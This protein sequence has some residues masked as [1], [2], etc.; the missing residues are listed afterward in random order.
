M[1]R[2]SQR[3]MQEMSA[4][5][6]WMAKRQEFKEKAATKNSEGETVQFKVALEEKEKKDYE[7]A[8]KIRL[9]N[10]AAVDKAEKEDND[11]RVEKL[12]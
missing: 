5:R 2:L 4:R 11:R 9:A 8:L 7:T 3:N 1:A 12:K 6:Q 10:E